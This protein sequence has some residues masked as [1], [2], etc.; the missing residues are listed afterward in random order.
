MP[1]IANGR[2]SSTYGVVGVETAAIHARPIACSASPVPM[3]RLR[4]DPVGERA[5][6][7][8]DDHRHRRPRED[9]QA[10]AER[11]VALHGLE[12]LREQEDRAEHPEAHQE[13]RDVRERERAVAEEAHRQHRM[14]ARAAPTR[15]TAAVTTAPATSAP[16]ISGEP[17]PTRVAADEPPHDPEQPDAREPEAAAG[18]RC[19]TGPSLSSR[20]G[21]SGEQHEPDRHVQPEDPV[22]RDAVD[23]GA[24]DERAERDREA[25]DAAPRAERH[26]APLRRAPPAERIV[27]VSG[28]TIAPPSALHRARGV[29]RADR[30]RE[31]RRRGGER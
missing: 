2:T 6:D 26:A 14:L 8:R 19:R 9:P 24:A 15:R 20:R 31:R 1:E 27:S 22:P 25:A 12:E 23:D 17:Q 13:R 16:T 11:R 3:M 18:R 10:R 29:E 5:G 30:R 21:T 4:R 7:R 28:I